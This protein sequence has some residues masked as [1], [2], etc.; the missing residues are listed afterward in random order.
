MLFGV[1]KA[2]SNFQ[3]KLLPALFYFLFYLNKF[4]THST[5]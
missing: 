2:G 1:K 4:T 3:R 5:A